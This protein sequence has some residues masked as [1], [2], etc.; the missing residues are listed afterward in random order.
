MLT[1][2]ARPFSKQKEEDGEQTSEDKEKAAK[3]G[4]DADKKDENSEEKVK[5]KCCV[6]HARMLTLDL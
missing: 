4:D 6:M 2:C 5:P 3:E 1:L